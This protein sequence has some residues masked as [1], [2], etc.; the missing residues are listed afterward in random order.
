M[1]TVL[2]PIF[3]FIAFLFLLL[4]SVSVPTI[5]SIYLFYLTT[6]SNPP[7]RINFGVWG[8]CIPTTRYGS[9]T[10]SCWSLIMLI[11]F[12]VAGIFRSTSAYCSP[13]RLGWTFDGKVASYL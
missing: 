2:T 7:L 13:T 9:V 5:K 3:S 6:A 4:V 12:R 11:L 10:Y 8:Y 1:F